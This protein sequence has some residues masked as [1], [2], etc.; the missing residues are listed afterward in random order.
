M[1]TTALIPRRPLRSNRSSI[2]A[3]VIAAAFTPRTRRPQYNGQPSASDTLTGNCSDKVTGCVW[4]SNGLSAL[5][6][7]AASSRATPTMPEQSL[8]FG[9]SLSMNNLSSS[10]RYSRRF[11]PTGA[12]PGNNHN[13]SLSVAKPSSLSEHNMPNDSTL[14]TLACL[15]TK[16]PGSTAPMRAHGTF[17]PTATFAAPHT[18]VRGRASPTFTWHTFRRSALGCLTTS[19][20]SATTTLLNAGATGSSASTSRPAMVSACARASLDRSGLTQVLNQ[21]SENF[22]A[23]CSVEL[24][25]KAQITFVEQAQI[26]HTVTQ[27]RQ[28]FHTQTKGKTKI[29]FAVDIDVLQ[30]VGMHHAAA[31]DFQPAAVPAHIYF[32][33][34]LGK[35]KERR[36]ETH[37]Q[38]ILLEKAL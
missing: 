11:F 18:M 6:V 4:I 38:I 15:M 30:H 24:L 1:S 7:S 33:R 27:H 20:T 25:E 32:S 3:G 14:R 35:R 31:A 26:V 10:S 37:L 29:F 13:P 5:P 36:T 2:Q 23:I 8:R 9:V 19:S 22:M 34:W 21:F 12:S 16:S 28:A 17:T